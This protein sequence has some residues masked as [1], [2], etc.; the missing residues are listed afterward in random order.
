MGVDTVGESVGDVLRRHAGGR[1]VNIESTG[2]SRRDC[3][4]SVNVD[5]GKRERDAFGSHTRRT[6]EVSDRHGAW[7]A[8]KLNHHGCGVGPGPTSDGQRRARGPRRP[9]ES[10]FV[11]VDLDEFLWR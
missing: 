8:R 9:G 10:S 5:A 6:A 4:V 3:S 2:R 1:A 11:E 7:C